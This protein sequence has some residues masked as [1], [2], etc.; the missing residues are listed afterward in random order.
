MVKYFLK[1]R[2]FSKDFLL[3]PRKAERPV[4]GVGLPEKEEEKDEKHKEKLMRKNLI[5]KVKCLYQ[6]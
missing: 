4:Q 1:G 2:S 5:I 3:T 6:H